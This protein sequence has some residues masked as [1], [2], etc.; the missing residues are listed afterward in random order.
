LRKVA[1]F[2]SGR[3]S[4]ESFNLLSASHA[5]RQLNYEWL[6]RRRAK[7]R[8]RRN[9]QRHLASCLQSQESAE[10][11]VSVTPSPVRFMTSSRGLESLHKQEKKMRQSHRWALSRATKAIGAIGLVAALGR[12]ELRPT[13]FAP[14]FV[15]AALFAALLFLAD[16]AI[17]Q[18]TITNLGVFTGGN[19]SAASAISADGST[20][21]GNS[22]G[23]VGDRAFRWTAGGGMQNLG[24]LSQT[25]PYS[26]GSALSAEC[27][28]VV[29]ISAGANQNNRAFRWT[30]A[31][32]MQSL[33]VLGTG[34]ASA[35][36]AISADGSVVSA[37]LKC[38]RR[39]AILAETL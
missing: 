29:G 22:N 27:S 26:A 19:F 25:G 33:G 1:P 13:C 18:P 32:G 14:R 12:N 11:Y 6:V 34:S 2:Q 3:D 10:A 31:S 36:N 35:A 15:R 16:S 30:A 38:G 20:V 8:R 4:L 24:I 28:V 39:A 5:C 7:K 9:C 17:G 23:N 37:A 21:T